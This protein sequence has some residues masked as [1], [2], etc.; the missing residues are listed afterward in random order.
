MGSFLK[1]HFYNP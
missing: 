1:T